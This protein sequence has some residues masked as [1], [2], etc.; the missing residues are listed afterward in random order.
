[1]RVKNRR[2]HRVTSWIL[3]ALATLGFASSGVRA[4]A[5]PDAN[6]A[7]DAGVSRFLGEYFESSPVAAIYAG[8]HEYD[9]RIDDLSD[10]ALRRNVAWL[11]AERARVQAVD[12]SKLSE[13][14]RRE[15]EQ[16]LSVLDEK[17]FWTKEADWPRRNPAYYLG[18]VDPE[19][20]LSKPYAPIEQR[21]KAY[22]LYAQAVPRA[23]Q[24]IRANLR[25]PMPV[26]WIEYGVNAFG[27]FASFYRNDVAVVFAQVKDPK[28]QAELTAANEEAARAMQGLADW[29]AAERPRATQ[30]FALGPQMFSRML[31]ATEQVTVPLDRLKEIG[32]SDLGRNLVALRQVCSTYAPGHTLR[33]CAD[34]ANAV[35]PEG[36]P[37]VQARRQLTELREFIAKHGIVT[38]PGPEQALVEPAP[39]YNAQNFAYIVTAGPYEA[40]SVPS[41][42]YI[43]PPDPRWTPQE[44]AQYI[45]GEGA[46]LSTSV[47]EVWPGH[48]LHFLHVNRNPSKI[49]QLFQSYAYTEG[50]AHYCEEMMVEQGL[51]GGSPEWRIGQLLQALKRD[52]RFLSAIGLHTAGMTVAQSEKLFSES[53]LQD[54]G[55]SRQ[56]ALRGTYDP[57]YLNYTLGKLMILKLRADWQAAHPQASLREFHDT[58]LSYGGPLPLVRRY[59]L[60]ND[61]PPL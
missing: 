25:T 48:F 38:I 20:Y 36:G 10:S 1:M 35:T 26:A 12:A 18:V 44:Q 17:L 21:M 37:V 58:F 27:G 59:M 53:A 47:H 8:K 29:L 15:R 13:P 32:E 24:Q 51:R 34:K 7:W 33:E 45:G 28:L 52:A 11:E 19:I 42:Y 60:G 46:L 3:L 41:V 6:T 23:A 5:A 31:A 61:S 57:A 4:D 55:N 40:P 16:L 54:P 39:P 22:I 14:R 9:G 2:P 30:D 56:Q 50:W 43:A 49:A